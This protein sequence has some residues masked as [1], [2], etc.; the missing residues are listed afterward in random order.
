MNSDLVMITCERCQTRLRVKPGLLKVMK[1]IKCSKCGHPIPVANVSTIAPIAASVIPDPASAVPETPKPEE[2]PVPVQIAPE[3]IPE[4]IAPPA[5]T[6]EY[7]TVP[8]RSKD[9]ELESL[10]AKLRAA[11]QE[12]AESDARISD[13]QERWHGKEIEV[14]EMSARLRVA[15]EEANRALTIR[16]EFLAKARNE[17][18]V[19][20]IGERDSA[21]SRFSELE[22]RLTTL[23]P[24]V[25][26]H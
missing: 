11:E 22:K 8:D 6:I 5:V 12:L 14:R 25:K 3:A 17:L 10:R 15:E 21:L 7:V 26:P 19:Y 23:Q 24:G 1:T 9:A 20:L 13:L 2:Q 18:A 16:D 4:K